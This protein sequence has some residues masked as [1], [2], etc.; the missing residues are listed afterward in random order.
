MGAGGVA[1]SPRQFIAS[2]PQSSALC[3]LLC[4]R[5]ACLLDIVGRDCHREARDLPGALQVRPHKIVCFGQCELTRCWSERDAI[6]SARITSP[7]LSRRRPRRKSTCRGV[8]LLNHR[9]VQARSWVTSITVSTGRCID[10][11]NC[12]GPPRWSR[13]GPSIE[14]RA[15]IAPSEVP[16]TGACGRR[17]CGGTLGVPTRGPRGPTAPPPV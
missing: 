9:G 14:K 6:D 4:D 13:A 7:A 1:S 2:R 12:F 5:D 15:F 8:M 3:A 10:A 11:D 16:T 17:A